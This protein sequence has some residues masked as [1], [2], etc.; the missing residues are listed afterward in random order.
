ML[1]DGLQATPAEAQAFLIK[2]REVIKPPPL[3]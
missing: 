1:A 3:F 2:G